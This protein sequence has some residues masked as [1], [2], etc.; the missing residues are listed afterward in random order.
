MIDGE[1][2]VHGLGLVD[3]DDLLGLVA[4]GLIGL[5]VIVDLI[6]VVPRD[7]SHV[8]QRTCFCSHRGGGEGLGSAGLK[9]LDGL[10]DA[11]HLVHNHDVVGGVIT[12]VGDGDSPGD[13]L[14][15]LVG[16]LVSGLDDADE[17][18]RVLRQTAADVGLV[19]A[20]ADGSGSLAYGVVEGGCAVSGRESGV[21]GIVG[22]LIDDGGIQL[23]LIGDGVGGH[24]IADGGGVLAQIPSLGS[25]IIGRFHADHGNAVAHGIGDAIG[26]GGGGDDAACLSCQI[27]SQRISRGGDDIGST[28]DALQERGIGVV[29]HCQLLGIDGS[30]DGGEVVSILVVGAGASVIAIVADGVGGGAVDIA[31]SS[32]GSAVTE[33]DQALVAHGDGSN[34]RSIQ[35]VAAQHETSLHVGTAHVGFV[36]VVVG[37]QAVNGGLDQCQI[38]AAVDID[39]ALYRSGVG[40][41]LHDGDQ[42]LIARGSTGN[43]VVQEALHCGLQ[44]RHV[45]GR[46]LEGAGGLTL[47]VILAGIAAVGTSLAAHFTS[48]V[49]IAALIGAERAAALVIGMIFV[50]T[51]EVAATG[52]LFHGVRGIQHQ[53]HSAVGGA[54][55][56]DGGVLGLY[57]QRDVKDI[58]NVGDGCGLG[59]MY[60]PV[61][62][63][64]CRAVLMI[65]G[66]FKILHHVG[67][68]VCESGNAA[69]AHQHGYHH[70]QTQDCFQCLSCHYFVLLFLV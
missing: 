38:V 27:H 23:H 19:E 57:Q 13:G 16:I 53:H 70:D 30:E 66:V 8:S 63:G 54:C 35:Q 9:S 39:P 20:G 68:G 28:K 7:D 69:D 4:L 40:V 41:E 32:G 50:L 45:G 37:G 22:V 46:L 52:G 33:E 6:A 14:A 24:A 67:C 60:L 48:L 11:H 26:V 55:Q 29:G 10:V 12:V 58:L 5:V 47:D 36:G 25:A 61:G 3:G 51:T 65:I 59:Q 64:G 56:L 31:H 44:Q 43:V 21:A 49:G 18:G 1:V 2:I 34:V 62:R 17:G 15:Y 42:T